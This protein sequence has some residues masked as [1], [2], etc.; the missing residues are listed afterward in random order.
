MKEA[1]EACLVVVGSQAKSSIISESSALL[2]CHLS[3]FSHKRLGGRK[4]SFRDRGISQF[5]KERN[6]IT[7]PLSYW[8]E[9]TP[10][11]GLGEK[12]KGK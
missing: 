9:T 7:P 8:E 5:D 11:P 12:D 4:G 1:G 10:D 3:T 2:E 6:V